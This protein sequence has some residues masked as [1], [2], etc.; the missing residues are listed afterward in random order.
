MPQ[1]GIT[2]AEAVICFLL[3]LFCGVSFLFLLGTWVLTH[4]GGIP[5]RCSFLVHW[6]TRCCMDRKH[7]RKG[8]TDTLEPCVYHIHSCHFGL[9]L[10][11]S[12]HYYFILIGGVNCG[13][14]RCCSLS[15]LCI[16]MTSTSDYQAARCFNPSNDG[17]PF[18]NHCPW[19]STEPHVAT[20]TW[21]AAPK[22]DSK[23]S[24][25]RS[26]TSGSFSRNAAYCRHQS[27]NNLKLQSD[28]YI[29]RKLEISQTTDEDLA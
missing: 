17:S 10:P 28:P 16:Q 2:L 7:V 19:Q 5:A 26:L 24:S 8:S 4:W 20:I 25:T 27:S 1:I 12:S 15:L 3:L 9:T 6:S 11:K 18:S 29:H 13:L 14:V 22:R 21:G 23:K